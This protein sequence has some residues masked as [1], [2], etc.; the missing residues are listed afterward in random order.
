[1]AI[2]TAIMIGLSVLN[3]GVGLYQK[4]KVKKQTEEYLKQFQQD[5]AVRQQNLNG[6]LNASGL[7]INALSNTYAN[8][9]GQQ[10]AQQQG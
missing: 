1:M 2:G 8:T 3:L 9:Y 6:F 4:H 10:G 5:M 7:D